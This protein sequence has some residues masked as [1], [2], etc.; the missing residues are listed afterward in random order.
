MQHQERKRQP[1]GRSDGHDK[2][3][4]WLTHTLRLS[5]QKWLYKAQFRRRRRRSR[6]R[7][8]ADLRPVEPLGGAVFAP[9]AA[10][11]GVAAAAAAAEMMAPEMAL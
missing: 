11:V 2:Q 10:A 6:K 1:A 7:L 5:R 3:T 8:T 4:N 9:T